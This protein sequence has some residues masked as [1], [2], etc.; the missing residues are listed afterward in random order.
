MPD[1]SQALRQIESFI[2]ELEECVH[3]LSK[4]FGP[5]VLVVKGKDRHVF[6]YKEI[7][8][9][10]LSMLKCVR[11]VSA[12]NASVVLLRAGH[13]FEVYALCRV[14]DE[15]NEEVTF[16]AVPAGDNDKPS[17]D[18]QRL[19][20]EFFQEEFEDE[21]NVV[22]TQIPRDRVSRK[23][24]R[25]AIANMKGHPGNPSDVIAIHKTLYQVFSGYLHG[26]YVHIMESYGGRP[27]GYFHMRGMLGTPKIQECEM[28]LPNYIFRTICSAEIVAM[29]VGDSG[30]RERIRYLRNALATTTGCVPKNDNEAKAALKRSKGEKD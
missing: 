5:P 27:P 13:I 10:L 17:D 3:A 8:D 20:A 29:R 11:A 12:L 4:H 25:A 30:L 24:I 22:G 15:C 26:A 28:Q 19:Y 14:V 21:T 9:L 2:A 1:D 6:R 23:R 16:M 7:N 18:Q